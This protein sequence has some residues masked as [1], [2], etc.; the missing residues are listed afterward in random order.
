MGGCKIEATSMGLAYKVSAP[1][2]PL[3]R[4]PIFRIIGDMFI[5]PKE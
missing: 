4:P 3:V 5:D 1:C 2:Q